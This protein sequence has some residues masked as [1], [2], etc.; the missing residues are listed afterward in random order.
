MADLIPNESFELQQEQF[1]DNLAQVATA[2][3]M[4]QS[5]GVTLQRKHLIGISKGGVFSLS[6]RNSEIT[7]GP[8]P[9]LS[10]DVNF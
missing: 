1:H 4:A 5:L 6:K 7:L 9:P 3:M 2:T 10:N 8:Y